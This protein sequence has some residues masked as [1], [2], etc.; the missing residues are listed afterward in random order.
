MSFRAEKLGFTYGLR[1][2]NF[3]LPES[4]F[5]A[6][7]GPNGAGKSTLVGVLAGVNRPYSGSCSYRETQLRDW[8][9]RKY[10]Q[11]VSFLPQS[12]RVDFP[13][14]AEQV[15]LMGR[16]PHA[17]GWYDSAEDLAS[18]E[19]AMVITDALPF[20]QRDV[21][22][23]SGG[24]RQRV[25]L[26]AA[27]AQQPR[28]LL[29]DEPATHL[30][31]KHQLAMFGLL[32]ELSSLPR[33]LLVVAVTHDLNMALRYADYAL[34]MDR[35]RVAAQGVPREMF[36][37]DLIERVFGIRATLDASGKW[38]QPPEPL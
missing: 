29:L 17:G 6:I 22:S 28:A 25:F 35:G 37:T 13:F 3:E 14:T 21:R 32:R 30:D 33:G 27:L 23:L 15:V 12:A 1:D 18:V 7:T 26:A 11:Q 24:E 31:L 34:V 8:P 10:A 16:T 19:R 2:A 20:R 9:R 38:F 36:Q 5:I 4:G